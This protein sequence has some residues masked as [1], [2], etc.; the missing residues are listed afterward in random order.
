MIYLICNS[1]LGQYKNNAKNYH[2]FILQASLV[3]V[4]GSLCPPPLVGKPRD[5]PLHQLGI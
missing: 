1:E 3:S 4:L 2:S 5:K